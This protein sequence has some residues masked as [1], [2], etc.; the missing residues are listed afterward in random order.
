MTNEIKEILELLKEDLYIPQEDNREYKLLDKG[1][2]KLLLDY[3][4]NLQEEKKEM[5]DGWQ[6]EIYDKNKVLNDWLEDER[7]INILQQ[8]IDK[9]DNFLEELISSTKGVINDYS[10]HK[11]HNKILIELFEED[12][13]FYKKALDILRG[14]E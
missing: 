4:I 7:K 10:Y 3:I 11:E 13:E 2:D 8:R 6:Q 12:I 14:D 1:D 9:A 5:K